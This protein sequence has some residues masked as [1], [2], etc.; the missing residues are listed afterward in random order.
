MTA[1]SQNFR[2][3]ILELYGE[4]GAEW[5]RDLPE[6]IVNYEQRWAIQVQQPFDLSYNYVAP[7]VRAGGT[8]VVFKAGVPHP[9]LFSEMSALRIFDGRGIA[10]LLE[11]DEEHG[12]ML[13]ERVFP[14]TML[15]D[16]EDDEQATSIAVQVMRQLWQPAPKVHAFPTVA[17]WAS[18]LSR[19]K[20]HYAGGTGPFP[21]GMVDRA[22]KLFAEL[23]CTMGE[24]VL[25]HGDFH[26]YNI[27]AA[28]RQPWLAIDPKGV[29]G[30]AEYELGAL[31]RNP[32]DRMI[33]EPHPARLLRRRID[34]LSDEL[35]FDRERIAAWSFAT[36][37][38]SCWWLVEDHGHDY[39]GP[40]E[41]AQVM[42]ELLSDI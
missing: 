41:L 39:E 27:L 5:L 2:T 17:D 1:V 4:Q 13:L 24:Q 12:V 29:I 26:H 7:A 35:G 10:R 8:P 11:A 21:P 15:A 25:L 23:I 16:L 28:D 40:I 20:G 19:I 32:W 22:E 3:T 31:L 18:G 6:M 37:V 38:L 14:G 36:Q 42:S 30:E 9:E 34:Q 33:S